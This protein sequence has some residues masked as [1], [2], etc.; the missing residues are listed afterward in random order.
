MRA[1]ERIAA[2]TAAACLGGACAGTP[3]L[4]VAPEARPAAEDASKGRDRHAGI[5]VTVDTDAWDGTSLAGQARPVEV[6]IEN[7]GQRT[8]RIRYDAFALVDGNGQRL[9]AL[10]PFSIEGEVVERRGGLRPAFRHR[11][12]YVAPYH[13]DYF[14]ALT[15]YAA[16]FHGAPFVYD[17][18]LGYWDRVDLPTKMMLEVAIPEG[19]LEPGG[20]LS[21]YLYF[22]A[23]GGSGPMDF[24]F[25]L[26]DEATGKHY[27]ELRIPLVIEP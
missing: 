6:L 4:V 12:F 3:E 7:D 13:A 23:E 2:V 27:G 16:T 17:H 20:V 15:P 18:Y 11:G 10:P 19:V 14:P 21:G 26:V 22:E 24:R 8:L 25:D 5:T 1:R 9:G